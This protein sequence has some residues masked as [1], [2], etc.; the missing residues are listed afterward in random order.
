MSFM[1]H[2]LDSSEDIWATLLKMGIYDSPKTYDMTGNQFVVVP[3]YS[4]R[5]RCIP[6]HT[7]V[8]Y[9]NLVVESRCSFKINPN[10]V[11]AIKGMQDATLT[12]LLAVT[13]WS[14]F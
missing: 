5:C 11:E 3:K 6:E 14:V 2:L 10:G 13:E 12:S 9:S 7:I 4:K 8:Y 1:A